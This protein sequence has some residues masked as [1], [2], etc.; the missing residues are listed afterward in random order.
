MGRSGRLNPQQH[1]LP[2]VRWSV[3]LSK[4]QPPS[5]HCPVLPRLK[6]K[7]DHADALL[8]HRNCCK[9]P[10]PWQSLALPSCA[11]PAPSCP[12]LLLSSPHL[13]PPPL[14]CSVLPS[15][16]RTP[17]HLLPSHADAILDQRQCREAAH[18]GQA[19][20][21]VR[22]RQVREPQ[23]ATITQAGRLNKC[24]FGQGCLA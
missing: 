18:D 5:N 21:G 13:L 10:S 23:R 7:T 22:Q 16:A 15:P 14:I 17:P 19:P 2:G 4:P 6:H 8:Q 20:V 3:D 1:H 24:T 9:P 12:D 11:A